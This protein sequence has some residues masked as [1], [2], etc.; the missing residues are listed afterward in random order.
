M[1]AIEIIKLLNEIESKFEVDKWII[2]DIHVWPLIRL[3][4]MMNLHFEELSALQTNINFLLKVR[5]ALKILS[6]IPKCLSASIRNFKKNTFPNRKIK[7]VFLGD[8]VS[9]VLLEGEWYDKFCDPFIDYFKK[10]KIQTF[11]MEPAHE[12]MIPR[13]NSSMFIQMYLDWELIKAK[14][15]FKKMNQSAIKLNKFNFF[16]DMLKS[17]KLN[18]PLPD[19]KRLMQIVMVVKAYSSFF[20]KV[21][22]KLNPVL[23]FVVGYYGP[24]G[25]AFNLAC[26]NLGIIS[27]DV[28]HGVAGDFNAAYGNWSKVPKEGY[29][30]LPS[31]FWCWSKT[32]VDA[33]EKWNKKLFRPHKA[34][35]GGNLLANLWDDNKYGS[36]VFL[37]RNKGRQNILI[38]L[39][40]I[41]KHNEILF[42]K[43]IKVIKKL[44][45]NWK[46]WIRLHPC[47]FSERNKVE[48]LLKE[49]KIFNFEIDIVNSLPLYS[50]LRHMDIH[51]T[52]VS[53]TV[54]DA[55]FF[56]VPS[57]ITGEDGVEYF[58][59]QISSGSA[60]VAYT[61]EKIEE[62][63]K[64][65]LLHKK[66][67]EFTKYNLLE[68][69]KKALNF[70]LSKVKKYR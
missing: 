19:L 55:D 22:K 44:P 59:K 4:L 27:V 40:S 21:L 5:E 51:I 17:K 47:N 41:G 14:L 67:A 52:Y 70:L 50:I 20:E 2:E 69:Q 64:Y 15:F 66:K 33:I 12:Y 43:I 7:A 3:D 18:M 49:N 26:N 36:N 25:M 31:V 28:Q 13:Y 46:W 57:I 32:D 10:N 11:L 65:F 61:P 53:A 45:K 1:R 58:R 9:K 30:L 16:L 23:G 48:N 42:K 60:K 63:I 38:T 29:E 35:L 37:E 62:V 54:I 68:D 56:A 34:L 24:R 6:G 39:S 8:G